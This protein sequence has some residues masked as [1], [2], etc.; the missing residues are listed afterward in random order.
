MSLTIKEAK[1]HRCKPHPDRDPE[2]MDHEREC[3][4][5]HYT[6]RRCELHTSLWSF[7]SKAGLC[8]ECNKEYEEWY[9]ETIRKPAITAFDA[10]KEAG[11]D[12]EGSPYWLRAA[13]A[14]WIKEAPIKSRKVIDI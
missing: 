2:R 1:A 13:Y 3:R 12:P 5:W 11:G 4:L 6:C 14:E 9:F 8:Y 10:E 7:N